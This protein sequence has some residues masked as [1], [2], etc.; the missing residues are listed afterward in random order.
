M[1]LRGDS[2][3]DIEQIQENITDYVGSYVEHVLKNVT[4]YQKDEGYKFQAVATFQKQFNLKSKNWFP[5]IE[6]A[7]KDAGNLVQS[8]QWVGVKSLS[9]T[10][11]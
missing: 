11:Y 4:F 10:L 3:K 1:G 5:M 8:G 7:L 9:L 2:M 6:Q